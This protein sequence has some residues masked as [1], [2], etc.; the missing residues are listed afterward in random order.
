MMRVAFEEIAWETSPAGV[1]FKVQK[2]GARQLRLLEFS[3][4]LVHP[5]W[6]T[7]GHLGYVLEGAMEVEFTTGSQ[8]FREGDGVAIPAGEVDKHRPR[9]LTERVRMI[10]VED[11][12]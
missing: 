7:T 3:R 11:A 1:R 10:F 8:V 2:V 9:A 6:C 5:H 4:A 12:S